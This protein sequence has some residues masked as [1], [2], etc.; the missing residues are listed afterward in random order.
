MIVEQAVQ[1]RLSIHLIW[2]ANILDASIIA[3][4]TSFLNIQR[5]IRLHD[6]IQFRTLKK[7]S[8]LGR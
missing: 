2:V 7:A 1:K 4:Q 3:S 6:A 8:P 5:F